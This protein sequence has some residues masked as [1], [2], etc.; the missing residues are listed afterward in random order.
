[1]S[2]TIGDNSQLKSIVE[3][4]ENVNEQIKELTD[5]RSDIFKEASGNGLDSK[6]LRTIIRLRAMKPDDRAAQ[7][8]ILD[9][10]KQALGM[11]A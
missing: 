1:M 8:A 3:R 6:A 4:I 10:Y 2:A 5:D 11:L 9:T 7:E